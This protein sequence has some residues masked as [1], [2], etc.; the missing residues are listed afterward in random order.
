M[1]A[2]FFFAVEPAPRPW[3]LE[4]VAGRLVEMELTASGVA[5]MPE[6]LR[7]IVERPR[8]SLTAANRA[9]ARIRAT[10]GD[11]AVVRAR[12]TDGHL[13][14]ASFTWEPLGL[15][16]SRFMTLEDETGFVNVVLWPQLLER[17]AVLAKTASGPMRMLTERGLALKRNIE[18]MGYRTVEC[19]PASIE[20]FTDLGLD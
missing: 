2:E 4:R 18:A 12:L 16:P 1:G 5:A 10:F 9:L 17:H 13:P 11:D 3:S 19:F 8:R 14:E 15:G 7:L 6:Q 20:T